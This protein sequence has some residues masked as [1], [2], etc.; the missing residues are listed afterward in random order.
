MLLENLSPGKKRKRRDRD[1]GKGGL[2]MSCASV[3]PLSRHPFLILFLY[4]FYIFFSE[5]A[6]NDREFSLVWVATWDS[7]HSFSREHQNG[8]IAEDNIHKYI[9]AYKVP[10]GEWSR[11]RLTIIRRKRERE[12]NIFSQEK[13]KEPSLS[14]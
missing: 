1:S 14:A 8:V 13:S 11:W 2:S 4:L 6:E 9:D 5:I 10:P 12:K 7:G 3:S